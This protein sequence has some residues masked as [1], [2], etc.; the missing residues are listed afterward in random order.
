MNVFYFDEVEIHEI[1][2]GYALILLNVR[3]RSVYRERSD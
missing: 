1:E 3:A 2:R